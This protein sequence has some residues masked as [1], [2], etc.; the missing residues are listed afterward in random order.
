M[1]LIFTEW[2]MII[3]RKLINC[4][5]VTAIFPIWTWS[6]WKS[7]MQKLSLFPFILVIK[8]FLRFL[9][10]TPLTT[11]SFPLN[12]LNYLFRSLHRRVRRK[13]STNFMYDFNSMFWTFVVLVFFLISTIWVIFVCN[14]F[15]VCLWLRIFNHKTLEIV[16]GKIEFYRHL[17]VTYGRLL[18]LFAQLPWPFTLFH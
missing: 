10:L 5:C 14:T 18:F 13:L 8:F 3:S 6:L 2:L 12:L 11:K 1:I 16:F 15:A 9:S 17:F 7:L 4:T